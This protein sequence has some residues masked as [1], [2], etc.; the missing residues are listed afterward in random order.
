MEY[1]SAC[2]RVDKQNRDGAALVTSRNACCMQ[3]GY[4]SKSS[5]VKQYFLAIIS[6]FRYAVRC[7]IVVKKCCFFICKEVKK[8]WTRSFAQRN[9]KIKQDSFRVYMLSVG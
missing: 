5:T 4:V 1:S 8:L 2:F 7:G 3:V 9:R 6:P